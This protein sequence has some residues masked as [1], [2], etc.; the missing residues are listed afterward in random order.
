VLSQVLSAAPTDTKLDVSEAGFAFQPLQD[1]VRIEAR[2][3][4]LYEGVLRQ[5]LREVARLTVFVVPARSVSQALVW[6]E[7]VTAAHA[8]APRPLLPDAASYQQESSNFADGIGSHLILS[9]LGERTI[10]LLL[11]GSSEAVQQ[12]ADALRQSAA[13]VT[14]THSYPTDRAPLFTDPARGYSMRPP[15]VWTSVGDGVLVALPELHAG[16]PATFSVNLFDLWTGF[17]LEVAAEALR[18]DREGVSVRPQKAGDFQSMRIAFD[19]TDDEHTSAWLVELDRHRVL[20]AARTPASRSEFYKEAIAAALDGMRRIPRQVSTGLQGVYRDSEAGFSIRPPDGFVRI[21][22]T[23]PEPDPTARRLVLFEEPEVLEPRPQ[24]R[25]SLLSTADPVDEQPESVAHDRVEREVDAG[26]RIEAGVARKII[27]RQPSARYATSSTMNSVD[28]I[29]MT[30]LVTGPRGM[31]EISF[32]AAADEFAL[33]SGAVDA[34]IL[35]FRAFSPVVPPALAERIQDPS[36]RI[37]IRP[38]RDWTRVETDPSLL[39]FSEADRTPKLEAGIDPTPPR[40]QLA[41]LGERYRAAI[42]AALEETGARH[43]RIEGTRQNDTAVPTY[44]YRISY[45]LDEG[46]VREIRYAIPTNDSVAYARAF[47]R[48]D[49]FTQYQDLL[50]AATRSLRR[51]NP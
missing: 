14:A 32:S 38:P 51:E 23:G 42:H 4:A 20:V 5:H 37:S 17:P 50:D 40:N 47:A 2:E 24:L 8:F 22:G 28:R 16:L 41:S 13:S 27:N 39:T 1:A 34:S 29:A 11:H 9:S 21:P 15:F 6:Q 46:A 36:G 44:S 19:D 35:T 31:F 26:A 25:I 30:T 10:A 48:S 33:Y 43:V 12:N 18:A 45:T 7:A 3:P 49:E